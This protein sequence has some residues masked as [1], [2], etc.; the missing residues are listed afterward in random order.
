MR[1]HCG[2]ACHAQNHAAPANSENTHGTGCRQGSDLVTGG[3]RLVDHDPAAAGCFRITGSYPYNNAWKVAYSNKGS[4]CIPVT[5][6]IYVIC[7]K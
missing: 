4:N 1:D 2:E 6:R 7:A 3:Y 5:I